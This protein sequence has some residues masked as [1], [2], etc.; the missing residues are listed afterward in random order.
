[1]ANGTNFVLAF[2]LAIFM[3]LLGSVAKYANAR[4]PGENQDLRRHLLVSFF[5]GMMMFFFGLAN[6]WSYPF[7]M[8]GCGLGGWRGAN[9]IKQINPPNLGPE[10]NGDDDETT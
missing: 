8:M 4:D 1:M 3:T 10:N 2:L 9:I 7:I 5:A 6:G